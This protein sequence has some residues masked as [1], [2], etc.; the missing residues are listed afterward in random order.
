MEKT[1]PVFYAIHHE[2]CTK[3]KNR[4]QDCVDKLNYMS[5]FSDLLGEKFVKKTIVTVTKIFHDP[6]S[7]NNT[8]DKFKI[9]IDQVVNKKKEKR[10]FSHKNY[11]KLCL[12][13]KL[14]IY[15]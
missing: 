5:Q 9:I 2:M 12:K 13:M 15:I 1:Y 3:D 7:E 14:S 8:F 4:V 10:V 6:P 11:E